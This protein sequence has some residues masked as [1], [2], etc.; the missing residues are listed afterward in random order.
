MKKLNFILI[1]ILL[2][3]SCS[4]GSFD[5]YSLRADRVINAGVDSNANIYNL[6][7]TVEVK[8]S[9]S[10]DDR[11]SFIIY[12]PELDIKYEG[13]IRNGESAILPITPGAHFKEG[14]YKVILS[15][16][17]GNDKDASFTLASFD[18]GN[19]P[20]IDEN[21]DRRGL[22]DASIA[23][24]DNDKSI[25]SPASATIDLELYDKAIITYKDRY[26][27]SITLEENLSSP[28]DELSEPLL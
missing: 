7:E 1:S 24:V 21:G 6:K 14:E 10:T 9:F 17:N 23:L 28:S 8:A 11:Y 3:S 19:P 18:L 13:D 27:T 26:G 16:E 20:Y 25:S 4:K 22:E 2:L 12:Y 15:D 5:L